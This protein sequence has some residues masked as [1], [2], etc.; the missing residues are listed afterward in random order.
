MDNFTKK[1]GVMYLKGP[2]KQ[3]YEHFIYSTALSKKE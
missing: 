2:Q 3:G 1:S